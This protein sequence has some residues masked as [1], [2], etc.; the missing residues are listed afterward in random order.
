MSRLQWN[1]FSTL[2]FRKGLSVAAIR[3]AVERHLKRISPQIAFWVHEKGKV[4]STSHVHAVYQMK[5][6]K[7]IQASRS[8][9]GL[10]WSNRHGI[11]DVRDYKSSLKGADYICKSIG[12]GA[13]DYDIW[14]SGSLEVHQNATD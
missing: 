8:E 4:E 6:E 9:I 12:L 3:R 13:P 1:Y 5:D 14:Y 11:A 10:D 7:S 2:T